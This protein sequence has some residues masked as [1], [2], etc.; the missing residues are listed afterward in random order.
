M[1]LLLY[2]AIKL[3]EKLGEEGNKRKKRERYIIFFPSFAL[4]KVML[5]LMK[6]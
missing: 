6:K 3:Q 2:R 4:V 5:M 1:T